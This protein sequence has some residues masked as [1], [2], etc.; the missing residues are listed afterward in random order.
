MPVI[1]S[2]REGGS[3]THRTQCPQFSRDGRLQCSAGGALT[4]LQTSLLTQG[5]HCR[6]RP[7]CFPPRVVHRARSRLHSRPHTC[8]L[9]RETRRDARQCACGRGGCREGAHFAPG[10]LAG[11]HA[12][13]AAAR[14]AWAAAPHTAEGSEGGWEGQRDGRPESAG[15][16]GFEKVR[17]G[18][19]CRA[20]AAPRHFALASWQR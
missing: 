14:V 8:V 12:A 7:A 4:V 1:R 10:R 18:W 15:S 5:Q 11:R 19:C 20:A 17:P 3:S 13:A 6:L 16:A 2:P 9:S